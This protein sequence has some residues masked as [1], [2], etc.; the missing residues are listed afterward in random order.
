MEVATEGAPEDE[1]EEV[2]EAG[3]FSRSLLEESKTASSAARCCG[4]AGTCSPVGGERQAREFAPERG[5]V[6]PVP[7][8]PDGSAVEFYSRTHRRWVRG[9]LSVAT[10]PGTGEVEAVVQYSIHIRFSRTT[11]FRKDVSIADFRPMLS[12][13]DRLE[14]FRRGS[15]IPCRLEG[16]QTAKAKQRCRYRICIEVEDC[17]L[18]VDGVPSVWLRRCFAV[19]TKVK[20]YVGPEAGW[21][22]AVVEAFGSPLV[23]PEDSHSPSSGSVLR[24]ASNS[25]DST[26]ASHMSELDQFPRLE[27][28]GRPNVGDVV[29]VSGR[30]GSI[31]KHDRN[32]QLYKVRYDDGDTSDWL[33]SDQ[34]EDAGLHLFESVPG[35]QRSE[36]KTLREQ[37]GPAILENECFD[38]SASVWYN[39][40]VCDTVTGHRRMVSSCRVF[41]IDA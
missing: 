9:K 28:K 21:R 17:S 23:E 19:G 22:T 5:K 14:V 8:L 12:E 26:A 37:F 35:G 30:A 15:W 24:C 18:L 31:V 27:D 36:V 20:L 29:S 1:Q 3:A 16:K 38:A 2:V 11:Q 32:N 25:K 39:V 34:V 13:S 4:A 6:E 7:I 40:A 10:V 41:P 33:R